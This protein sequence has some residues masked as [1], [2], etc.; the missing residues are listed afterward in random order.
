MRYR[1]RSSFAA[2]PGLCVLS[3]CAQ[4]ALLAPSFDGRET[5]TW[6]AYQIDVP[7]R[8]PGDLIPAFE[9]SARAFGCHTE[10]IEDGSN[11]TIANGVLRRFHG[12]VAT[13]ELGTVALIT[14]TG[15]RVRIGC[16]KPATRAECDALV[17]KISEAR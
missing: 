4:P 16:V 6:L 5:P 12:V 13:C 10:R 11:A 3:A 15:D 7:G 8:D 17:E 1:P 9:A 14:L 2:F